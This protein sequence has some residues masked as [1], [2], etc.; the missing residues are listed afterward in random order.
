MADSVEETARAL[1]RFDTVVGNSG[2]K[3]AFDPNDRIGEP[4]GFGEVFR[5]RGSH[6]EAVA[7][8]RVRMP[9]G[10][11]VGFER[12]REREV[13]IGRLIADAGFE[14]KHLVAPLDVGRSGDDLFIVMPLGD[15]SLAAALRN[16]GLDAAA[17]LDAVGQVAD[18]LMELA[19]L[20]L[21]HRDL[22]PGNVLRIGERWKLADFGMARDLLESTATYTFRGGGTWPYMAPEVWNNQSA[23]VKTDLYAFGVLAYDVLTGG[24]PFRGPD[25][26]DFRRQHLEVAPPAPNT[27]RPA[28]DRLLL[29]LL[30]KGPAQ[31]PQDARDVRD[32]LR[33]MSIAR[34]NEYPDLQQAALS[35]QIR[36]TAAEAER[37]QQQAQARRAAEQ[38]RQAVA[39]LDDIIASAV[40]EARSE[41]PEVE[42]KTGPAARVSAIQAG[43]RWRL[44]FQEA[45]VEVALWS[46]VQDFLGADDPYVIG[47]TVTIA[48]AGGWIVANLVC[49][50]LG[51]R[52][53]WSA[54]EFRA[55]GFASASYELGPI[56]RT[57][58]FAR[59]RFI[60][61]RP[62]MLRAALHIWNVTTSALTPDVLLRFLRTAIDLS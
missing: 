56:D 36:T 51:D 25:E 44:S 13:E 22:K 43:V 18:G 53:V 20:S 29:R 21:L 17:K 4:G 58:G 14:V 49:E 54:L 34:T 28:L 52:L 60:E 15:S 59:P 1:N 55:S 5:G 7:I 23:T 61:Q 33:N 19:Q 9:S 31:R 11:G 48:T 57:H 46:D 40:D 16:G 37:Q 42:L 41:L 32:R 38:M 47:G 26:H 8:K 45:H 35:A 27:G 39:D 2:T 30:A 12:L 10:G 50:R 24:S 62:Y 6:G 3:W